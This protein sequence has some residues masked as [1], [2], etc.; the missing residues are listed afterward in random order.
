MWAHA[1]LPR[2]DNNTPFLFLSF[3]YSISPYLYVHFVL[4]TTPKL[5][6][7]FIIY[8]FGQ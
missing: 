5:I 4:F 1:M 2:V 3:F 7:I 6:L 8:K